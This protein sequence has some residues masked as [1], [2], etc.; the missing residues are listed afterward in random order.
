M[1]DWLCDLYTRRCPNE[2]REPYCTTVSSDKSCSNAV[3]FTSVW[4]LAAT[5]SSAY[6]LI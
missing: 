5:L 6:A 3:A 2:N 1:C 4:I